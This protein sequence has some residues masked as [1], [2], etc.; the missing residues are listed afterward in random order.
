MLVPNLEYNLEIVTNPADAILPSTLE[1]LRY[2]LPAL[3]KSNSE[4]Y[5]IFV[6]QSLAIGLGMLVPWLNSRGEGGFWTSSTSSIFES[7]AGISSPC[8]CWTQKLNDF[9]CPALSTASQGEANNLAVFG[10]DSS[11]V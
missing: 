10:A 3:N 6:K 1:E 11:T 7:T 2:T 5:V 4:G 8:S 9:F